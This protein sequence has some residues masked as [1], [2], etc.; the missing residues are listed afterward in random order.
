MD[1]YHTQLRLLHISAV[2]LS[3]SLFFLR[4][5]AIN[6][7]RASWPMAA[8]VRYLTYTVDTVLLAAALMLTTVVHQYPFVD[9]WL[10]MK[11]VCLVFYIVLGSYALKRGRTPK[12]RLIAWV[13]ALAV[14]LFIISVAHTRNP[15]GVFALGSHLF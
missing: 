14:F 2:M 12:V 10:T 4:G 7:F 9:G 6:I 13:S 5:L 1:A 15:A 3:G 11:V 8:P